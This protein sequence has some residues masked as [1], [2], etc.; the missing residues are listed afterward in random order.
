MEKFY[1][2]TP[3]YY[4]SGQ[5]HIGHAFNVIFADTIARW[6]NQKAMMSFFRRT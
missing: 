6:E 5:P 2:T 4:A 3:I 1:I